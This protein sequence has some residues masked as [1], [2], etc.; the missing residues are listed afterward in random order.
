MTAFPSLLTSAMKQAR[1]WLRVMALDD[2]ARMASGWIPDGMRITTAP[3]RRPP[4][5]LDFAIPR[6][7]RLGWIYRT[8]HHRPH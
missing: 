6:K 1:Y 3:D 7:H 8:V 4:I 5:K 2:M